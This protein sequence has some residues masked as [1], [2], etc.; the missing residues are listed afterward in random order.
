MC[1]S[2][3]YE[4][5]CKECIC[6]IC[7]WTAPKRPQLPTPAYL[8]QWSVWCTCFHRD[9]ISA[10]VVTIRRALSMN[11]SNTVSAREVLM[12]FSLERGT[13]ESRFVIES[14]YPP[15][16]IP[17]PCS[18]AYTCSC[19]CPR[20]CPHTCPCYLSLLPVPVTCPRYLS[21]LPVPVTCPRYL[22]PLPIPVTYPCY[23]SLYA[24]SISYG[25]YRKKVDVQWP[26]VWASVPGHFSKMP[27]PTVPTGCY[28][29]TIISHGSN[30]NLFRLHSSSSLLLES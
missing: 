6:I 17:I 10:R 19:T 23:L 30:A 14:S 13:K 15:V 1:F 12:T 18:C 27:V 20:T 21:P 3:V 5:C 25:T 11:S 7:S 4:N 8:S 2:F 16:S 29:A 24:I 9:A 26:A 28:E 22:S